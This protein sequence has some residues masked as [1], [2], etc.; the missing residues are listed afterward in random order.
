[1]RGDPAAGGVGTGRGQCRRHLLQGRPAF[2]RDRRRAQ[3]IAHV[4]LAVEGQLHRDCTLGGA[5]RETRPGQFIKRDVLCAHVRGLGS[6]HRHDPCG[7]LGR[8]RGNHRVV[9][10]EYHHTR[11]W[12]CLY[13]FGFRR[14]DHLAGAELTEVGGADVEH[15]R[16]GRRCD[17]GQRGDIAGMPG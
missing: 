6:S 7:G 16:D 2:E 11:G 14:S 10:V 4:V 12:N 8:H 3:R 17:P 9:S 1:M 5:Q 13:Q 15:H